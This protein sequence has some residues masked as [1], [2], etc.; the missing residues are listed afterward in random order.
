MVYDIVSFKVD[1]CFNFLPL[2]NPLK[3]FHFVLFI[4]H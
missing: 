4:T 1:Y 3:F 2:K